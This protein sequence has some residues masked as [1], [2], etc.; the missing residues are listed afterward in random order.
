VHQPIKGTSFDN[1]NVKYDI[2]L[3]TNILSK[4]GIELNYSEGNME[5]FDCSIPLCP[6]G[7]L[8]SKEFD[9]MEDMFHIQVK[10]EI[11]GEDWLE[12]F[13]KE[14]LDAKYDKTDVDKVVKGLT[15]LKA[16][17]KADLL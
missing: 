15:Y 8:D 5:W 1:D 11:F 4:T 10:D 3:G 16:H 13:A 14:I 17:Q 9:S 6:P 2:I 12:C 7:G